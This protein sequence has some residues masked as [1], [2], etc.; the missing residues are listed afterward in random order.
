M[1]QQ[2]TASGAS[3]TTWLERRRSARR[4]PSSVMSSIGP[5]LDLSASGMRAMCARPFEGDFD[6]TIEA[7]DGRQVHVRASAKWRKRVGFRRFV[8]GL[9]FV[10]VSPDVAR[11]LAKLGMNG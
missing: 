10:D 4:Q 7:D 11:R 3:T 8:V 1:H 2:R 5:V 9:A 6:V